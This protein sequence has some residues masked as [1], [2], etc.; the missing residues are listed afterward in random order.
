MCCSQLH[1]FSLRGYIALL[2]A[3][4]GGPV[5]KKRHFL[6]AWPTY[7]FTLWACYDVRLCPEDLQ[8]SEATPRKPGSPGEMQSVLGGLGG[9]LALKAGLAFL[10][11][12]E[13]EPSTFV[14]ILEE[15]RKMDGR[16]VR[17]TSAVSAKTSP[18]F[19]RN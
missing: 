3:V 8:A 13:K 9:R 10:S 18:P 19:N 2:Q 4:L 1:K 17:S 16:G 14:N 7:Y 15:A 11:P 12:S 6:G 5:R